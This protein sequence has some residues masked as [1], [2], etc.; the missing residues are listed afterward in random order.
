MQERN[1]MNRLLIIAAGGTI[2]A[3]EYNFETGSVISSHSIFRI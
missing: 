2:D 1:N 3:A